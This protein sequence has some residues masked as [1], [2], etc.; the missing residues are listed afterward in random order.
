MVTGGQRSEPRIMPT[1]PVNADDA[2]QK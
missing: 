2:R 1:M